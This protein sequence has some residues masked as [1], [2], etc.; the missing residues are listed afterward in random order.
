M[1]KKS[2]LTYSSKTSIGMIYITRG[3]LFS[4][5]NTTEY[6]V[7]SVKIILYTILSFVLLYSLYSFIQITPPFRPQVT[8]DTDTR[9][10]D[11]VFTGDSVELTP[12]DADEH[13]NLDPL[14]PTDVN[15]QGFSYRDLSTTLGTSLRSG[16]LS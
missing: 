6:F 2:C 16:A 8:S 14:E 12:P 11:T 15:F 7:L 5:L 13:L 3:Y 9:Y 1:S 10:F 4:H